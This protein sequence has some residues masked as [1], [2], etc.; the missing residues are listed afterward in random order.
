VTSV[1]LD[2]LRHFEWMEP[3][4]GGA[5]VPGVPGLERELQREV[6]AGHALYHLANDAVAVARRY[7]MDDVLFAICEREGVPL[8]FAEVHLSWPRSRETFPDVP[9]TTIYQ[10]FEQW[11]EQ[12]MRRDHAQWLQLGLGKGSG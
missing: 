7:D 2:D 8:L 6:G 10:S 1:T 5:G 3:W 4:H 12:S 9:S 11:V